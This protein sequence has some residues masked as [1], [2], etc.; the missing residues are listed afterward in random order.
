MLP[1]MW[2]YLILMAAFLGLALAASAWGRRK[3]NPT[4][5]P[6]RPMNWLAI[7]VS[8]GVA[9]AVILVLALLSDS[10]EGWLF[11]VAMAAV[12]IAFVLIAARIR[13]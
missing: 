9:F 1:L 11:A 2:I 7:G 3:T 10:N 5:A 8:G 4:P 13:R 6:P 12:L